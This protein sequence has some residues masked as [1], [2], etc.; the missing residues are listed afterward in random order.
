MTE[1][2]VVGVL[3]ALVAL[4]TA[5]AGPMLKLNTTMTRLAVLVEELTDKL[6]AFERANS[7][8]HARLEGGISR[9]REE[10]HGQETRI[11]LLELGGKRHG[12]L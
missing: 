10:L 5:L 8:G 7:A 1:W 11:S 9:L 4:A 2:G 3:A 12:G 6:A